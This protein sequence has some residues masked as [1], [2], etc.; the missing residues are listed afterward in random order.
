MG[1]AKNRPS[2]CW[3]DDDFDYHHPRHDADGDLSAVHYVSFLGELLGQLTTALAILFY[4]ARL[5]SAMTRRP[6]KLTPRAETKKKMRPI[7][8]DAFHKMLKKAATVPVEP[9]DPK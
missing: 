2:A 1:D 5:G 4:R 3:R 8:R 6:K 7:T 9:R